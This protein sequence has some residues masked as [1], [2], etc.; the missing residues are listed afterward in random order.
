[1]F[2]APC[3]A[4]IATMKNELGGYR[5]MFISILFQTT[6]AWIL[7]TLIYQIYILIF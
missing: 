5:K 7:A 6:L 2:S 4:T 1:L 3:F